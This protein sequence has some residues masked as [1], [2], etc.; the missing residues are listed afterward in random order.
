MHFLSNTGKSTL[1]LNNHVLKAQNLD[2]FVNFAVLTGVNKSRKPLVNKFLRLETPT[3][4]SESSC[5]AGVA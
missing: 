3:K 5:T 2:N 4:Q 1:M